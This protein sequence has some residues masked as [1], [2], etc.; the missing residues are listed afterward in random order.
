LQQLKGSSPKEGPLGDDSHPAAHLAAL[1]K[2][3]PE[4]IG[5]VNVQTGPFDTVNPQA[6]RLFGLSCAELAKVGPV[7]MS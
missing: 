3:S 1:L 4:A 2:A 7:Q 6:E 5:V